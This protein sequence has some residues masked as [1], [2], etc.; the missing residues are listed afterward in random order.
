MKRRFSVIV[1]LS[2]L[3][4]LLSALIMLALMM[5]VDD[6]LKT[7]FKESNRADQAK[8]TEV[9]RNQLRHDAQLLLQSLSDSLGVDIYNQDLSAIGDALQR[10]GRF[11]T[12]DYI[13]VY[14]HN[15]SILHDG[16]ADIPLYGEPITSHTPP[17][18]L[19]GLQDA[20]VWSDTHLY[21]NSRVQ[22]GNET[23]A[24][25]S[26]G[27]DFSQ[28]FA[29]LEAHNEDL[30]SAEYGLFQNVRKAILITFLILLPVCMLS[31]AWITRGMLKPLQVLTNRSSRFAEGERDL[32]FELNR[33]DEFGRLGTALE[34]MRRA[35]EES[36][37]QVEQMAYEDTVTHLPNR[38]WFQNRLSEIMHRSASLEGA[39]AVLF[40][41]LDHFK[42]VNDT[43][44]HERGDQLLREV[45]RRLQACV[46]ENRSRRGPAAEL[47]RLGG[48]EFVVLLPA[49]QGAEDAAET[50]RALLASLAP[51]F[52]LH[53]QY[54]SI[55]C[56]IGIT[57]YP[58]DGVSASEI[59]KHAD[60]AMYSAKQHGR[61]QFAFFQPQ[62]TEEIRE[63]LEIQQGIKEAIDKDY[64]YLDYQP[65]YSMESG[66]IIGAEAL[67]RWQHPINGLL[68]P[69]RFIPIIEESDLI[70]EVTRW[71]ANRAGRDLQKILGLREQ[72]SMSIN[73][74]GAALHQMEMCDYICHLKQKLALP[75]NS[76]CIEITE[77]SM[78]SHLDS[79]EAVLRRWKQAGIEIWIDD[80][81]TGY[82][83]LAY[84]NS[85][86]ID[87]LKIDQS[88]VHNLIDGHSRPLI[89]AMIALADS[90]S[91]STVAEGI[92]TDRQHAE[93]K[94]MGVEYAQGFGLARPMRIDSLIELLDDE[95]RNAEALA[96]P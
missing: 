67:L 17:Q 54:F 71:V 24:A 19:T 21:L 41:D 22:I 94:A 20:L 43:A 2:L 93:L 79:C 80:F 95:H 75:D 61:N 92:E 65:L 50:A 31:A 42:Q 52:L 3:L 13:Y 51:P 68:S 96:E 29:E 12:L 58:D 4:T 87:G 45:S 60:V 36:H 69:A 44:G 86:S 28:A 40:I 90:L 89:D 23:F 66:E 38:R 81:G 70:E 27:F 25:I 15:G 16:S 33:P 35:L 8:L 57:L 1:R 91:I 55:S 10:L 56:S 62:M 48:D 59:L 77:T 5:A 6:S 37:D 18:L 84:L 64:L 74:S 39:F 82:S 85:L 34:R 11:H 88:F 7:Y 83:S 30:I 73:I 14:D 9:A 76:L 47:A 63:H 78:I 53:G 32:S 26:A 49:V 72:F 46:T